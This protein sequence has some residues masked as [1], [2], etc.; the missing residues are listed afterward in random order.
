METRPQI[1]T[2]EDEI[3]QIVQEGTERCGEISGFAI[4][5]KYM[6]KKDALGSE[7]LILSIRY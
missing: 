7:F 3:Y 6:Y 4:V 1:R 2:L 5:I